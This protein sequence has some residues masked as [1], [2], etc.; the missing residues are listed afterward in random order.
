MSLAKHTLEF[1]LLTALLLVGHI[2]AHAN[3]INTLGSIAISALP[4]CMLFSIGL[5]LTVSTN[6]TFVFRL[7]SGAI[8]A[9]A[10]T[11]IIVRLGSV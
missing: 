9:V 4:V 10:C 2:V 1:I 6:T 7:L 11:L 3:K 8:I 5:V